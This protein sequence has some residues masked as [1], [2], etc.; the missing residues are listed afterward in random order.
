MGRR[1]KE[2]DFERRANILFDHPTSQGRK[3]KENLNKYSKNEKRKMLGDSLYDDEEYDE[4]EDSE[5][6]KNSKY[7]EKIKSDED[8]EE[9]L[10]RRAELLYPSMKD[11]DDDEKIDLNANRQKEDKTSG[12]DKGVMTGAAASVKSEE[13]VLSKDIRQSARYGSQEKLFPYSTDK[14]NI[15]NYIEGKIDYFAPD[16]R[17][18]NS[19][20]SEYERNELKKLLRP[21]EGYRSTG[22]KNGDDKPTIGYGHTAGVK[23]GD[24]I[25]KA[26]AEK[27]LDE[28]ITEHIKALNAVKV[29]LNSN[30]KIALASLAYNI[31]GTKFR[32][33]DLVKYLNEYKYDQAAEEFNK[34]VYSNG[35]KEEG[36]VLRRGEEKRLFLKK[37]K[38][39]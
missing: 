32:K 5:E 27:Y 30:Q 29:P 23:K 37:P 35:K 8:R 22:Y 34:F 21:S 36:L 2:S 31:G 26:Q 19:E 16:A 33:S 39:N 1:E 14:E 20:F 28:D 6:K 11:K 24:K 4:R 15:T 3:V 17:K 13:D 7:S 18:Y 10:Q 9:K 25:T 12:R 38:K